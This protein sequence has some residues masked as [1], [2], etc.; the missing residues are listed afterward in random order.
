VEAGRVLAVW[1]TVVQ[2]AVAMAAVAMAA[3]AMAE[4]AVAV[5]EVVTKAAALHR[6]AGLDSEL[7]SGH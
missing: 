7:R 5:A 6:S 4:A 3:V 1:A 2:A